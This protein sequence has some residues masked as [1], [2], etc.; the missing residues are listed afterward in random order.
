MK[1]QKDSKSFELTEYV[2]EL[3]ELVKKEETIPFIGREKQIQTIEETLLR[4]YKYNV[5]LSGLP[6]VGKT[7]LIKE[8]ARRIVSAE[9]VPQ[10]QKKKIILLSMQK[11]F[12]S[13]ES[14]EQ[15]LLKLEKIFKNFEK[16]NQE[17]I[18]FIDDLQFFPLGARTTPKNNLLL[19]QNLLKYQI[20]THAFPLIL[21]V[22]PEE[23]QRIV[24]SDDFLALNFNTIKLEEPNEEQVIKILRGIT[25]YFENYYQLKIDPKL[26][27][28]IYRLAQIYLPFRAFPDKAIELLDNACSK[29]T[30]K[31]V[32]ELQ[33]EMIYESLAM[34]TKLDIAVIKQ[35][36]FK[37]L[38][39]LQSF[40][41]RQIVNQNSAKEE[42]IRILN[43][44]MLQK[45][46][47]SHRPQAIFLFLGPTGCGKSHFALK[48]AEFLF[49]SQQK[50]RQINLA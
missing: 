30:L 2:L 28:Q 29:A 47:D 36:R 45:K 49:N 43:L 8:L 4:K 7:A 17:T 10:L 34:L 18:L 19:F 21:A 1:H 25:P 11:L 37:K 35:D 27:N 38:K 22:T 13:S 50:L 20:G 33:S 6:G 44:S 31:K 14:V 23:E 40:L 12:I 5:L 16:N 48:L 41:D 39:D 15:A 32:P 42:V 24:L 3:N 9:V 46:A 26:F